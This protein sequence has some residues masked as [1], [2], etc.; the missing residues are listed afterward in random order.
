MQL[1]LGPI[2]GDQAAW[3]LPVTRYQAW[4]SPG[5]NALGPCN[6]T[7]GPSGERVPCPASAA[8][9]VTIYRKGCPAP[10]SQEGASIVIRPRLPR[11]LVPTPVLIY[12]DQQSCIWASEN[13]A[14]ET[15]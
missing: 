13:F 4:A 8:T 5:P 11:N 3:R 15:V 12:K 2:K 7:K 1:R 6:A 10:T 9:P 14:S